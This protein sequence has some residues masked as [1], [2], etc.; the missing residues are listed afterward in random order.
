[1]KYMIT[2]NV[3]LMYCIQ[4]FNHFE[5]FTNLPI[6]SHGPVQRKLNM[7]E[8]L[9]YSNT[10]YCMEPHKIPMEIILYLTCTYIMDNT[11][12]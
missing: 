3:L 4:T 6:F 1:M 12:A 9:Q 11:C 5:I 7:S 8:P 2:I 10:T